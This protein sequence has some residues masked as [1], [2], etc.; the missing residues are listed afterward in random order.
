MIIGRPVQALLGGR[1][2]S[3][4]EVGA[5]YPHSASSRAPPNSAE[6]SGH[7]S[8]RFIGRP[9]LTGQMRHNAGRYHNGRCAGR[10]RVSGDVIAGRALARIAKAARNG[11]GL[12]LVLCVHVRDGGADRC[13]GVGA[14]AGRSTREGGR[15]RGSEPGHQRGSRSWAPSCRLKRS[16]WSRM[17]DITSSGRC[18]PLSSDGVD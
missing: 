8:I 16:A 10:P 14:G 17:D 4:I 2:T 13:A 15:G 1:D 6:D 5:H 11:Q 3:A 7:V 12:G 18:S 9:Y